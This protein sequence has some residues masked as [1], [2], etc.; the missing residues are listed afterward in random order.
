MRKLILFCFIWAAL[1]SMPYSV[2]SQS[3][4]ITYQII[5]DSSMKDMQTVKDDVVNQARNLFESI[6]ED[7]YE[8]MMKHS[9]KLFEK[10]NRKVSYENHQLNIVVGDGK[11]KSIKGTFAQNAFCISEVKPRS[12]VMELLNWQ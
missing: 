7:S 9:L 1:L 12:Y 4:Q 8:T 6:H 2:N 5:Y 11:G 10:E 3:A